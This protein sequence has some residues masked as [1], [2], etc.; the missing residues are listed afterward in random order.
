MARE[1]NS[2]T[3]TIVGPNT[4]I[5]GNLDI[6]GSVLVYGTVLG[7]VRSNGQVRTAKDSI[8]KGAVVAQEAI[9]DGEL[10]GSLNTKGRAT[11][12]GSARMVGDL[13]AE[14]LVIEEGAQYS[15]KCKMQGAKIKAAVES[16]DGSPERQTSDEMDEEIQL[17]TDT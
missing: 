6:K 3:N 14:L 15:G 4:V 5:Q 8:I 16:T 10:D 13:R 1:E 7:D 12:G 9:I 17:E 11:L 2:Q